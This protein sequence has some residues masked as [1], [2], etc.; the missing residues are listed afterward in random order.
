MMNNWYQEDLAYIHDVGFSDHAIKATAGIIDILN[1]NNIKDGLIVDLGCGS[2]LSAQAF[3]HAN[4]QVLGIDISESMIAIARQRVP[5]ATFQVNS[6]LKADIPCCQVVTS[7]SECLN[8]LFDLDNNFPTLNQ[9]FDR[10][11]QALIP[12]GLFIFD[13]LEPEQLETEKTQS[14]VEGEDWIVLVEKT[15]D[16]IKQRLTRRIITF[17]QLEDTYRRNEEVHQVQLYS[18]NT[19]AEVLNKIGFKVER[20]DSYSQFKLRKNHSVIVAQK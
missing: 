12:G 9:L 5:Q 13:I 1:Q 14:F 11:Y 7:I 4:Y 17:R 6:L 10:I 18:A 16:K 2:G 19:L 15:E 3:I 20:K 8:Y